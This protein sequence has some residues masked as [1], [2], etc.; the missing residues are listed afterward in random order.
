MITIYVYEKCS[1]CQSA[2]RFLQEKNIPFK[3]QEITKT[4]PSIPEL[5]KMLEYVNHDIKKLF[6]TS[7]LLYRQM[8]LSTKLSSMSLEEAL[9]LLSSQG[10]LVKRPFLLGQNFGYVGFSVSKW[11]AIS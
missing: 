4:P 5:K 6:N 2:I 7:G 8:G 9:T 3:K 11:E 1:T 10:M